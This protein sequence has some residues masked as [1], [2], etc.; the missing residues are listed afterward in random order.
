MGGDM[1]SLKVCIFLLILGN[2]GLGNALGATS[3]LGWKPAK[4]AATVKAHY[5]TVDPVRLADYQTQL[6]ALLASGVPATDPRAVR[7]QGYVD[8]AKTGAKP[9][10]VTCKG[11]GKKAVRYAKFHCSAHLTGTGDYAGDY[12]ATVKLTVIATS[13]R[14]VGGW[15]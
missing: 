6:D 10:R 12:S 3:S 15:R 2:V 11:V 14:I 1:S 7:L 8:D 5:V 4:A 9:D 13:R